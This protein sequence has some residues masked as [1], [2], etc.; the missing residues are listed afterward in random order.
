MLR[1]M[2]RCAGGTQV[3]GFTFGASMALRIQL[4]RENANECARR[5]EQS[6]DPL[7][8]AAYREM[9]RAWVMLAESA[10]QLANAR[11]DL[12]QAA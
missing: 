11:P 10:E 6:R 1:I 8:R 2:L 12:A 7:A 4:Y 9:V 5:A 3:R